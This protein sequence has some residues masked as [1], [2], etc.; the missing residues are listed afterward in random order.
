MKYEKEKLERS[1]KLA[2]KLIFLCF[3]L[4]NAMASQAVK[5][6]KNQNGPC[7]RKFCYHVR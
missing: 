3:L 1:A 5:M 4:A 7:D 6:L 2:A